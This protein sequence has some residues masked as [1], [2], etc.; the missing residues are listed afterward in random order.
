MDQYG[1][2]LDANTMAVAMKAMASS[3]ANQSSRIGEAIATVKFALIGA[4]IVGVVLDPQSGEA[5]RMPSTSTTHGD[6][7]SPFITIEVGRGNGFNTKLYRKAIFEN[8]APELYAA[9]KVNIEKMKADKGVWTNIPWEG[10]EIQVVDMVTDRDFFIPDG[11]G[12]WSKDKKGNI[13][14]HNTRELLYIPDI[15]NLQTMVRRELRNLEYSNAF[16]GTVEQAPTATGADAANQ[17]NQANPQ[18]NGANQQQAAA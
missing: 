17:Q 13:V 16:G 10:A 12:G 5:E 1:T 18:G 2:H 11:K 6:I 4:V 7:Q 14:K 8:Q 15:D 9:L 3:Q